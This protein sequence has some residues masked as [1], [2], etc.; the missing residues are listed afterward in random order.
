M[1]PTEIVESLKRLPVLGDLISA[2]LLSRRKLIQDRSASIAYF[3]FFSIFPLI[4]GIIA[5]ASYFMD[6]GKVGT[7]INKILTDIA[8]ASADFVTGNIEN[9][10]KIRGAMS[11]VSIVMLFWSG[12]KMFSAVSRGINLALGLKP[13]FLSFLDIFRNF[14][15]AILAI[16]LMLVPLAMT[17]LAHI[18][19]SLEISVFGE[20]AKHFFSTITAGSMSFSSSFLVMT[21]LYW[22]VP[23]RWLSW[24]IVIPAAF[25]TSI[26]QVAGKSFF[27]VYLNTTANFKAIYGSLSSIVVLLLWLYFSAYMIIYGAELMSVYYKKRSGNIENIEDAT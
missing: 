2:F 24:K 7:D 15:L 3:S 21:V 22:I 11:L 26:F 5:L 9:L 12:K 18:I 13:T 16:L 4:L 23:Y 25:F 19:E 20:N 6:P 8:P 1:K 14:F 27:M 10:V 17:P